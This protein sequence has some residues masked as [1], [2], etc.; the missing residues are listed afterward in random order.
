MVSD[1]IT[2]ACVL[3]NDINS[4]KQSREDIFSISSKMFAYKKPESVM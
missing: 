1:K 3:A 4:F 2:R